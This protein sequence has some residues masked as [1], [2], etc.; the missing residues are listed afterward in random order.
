[1]NYIN[2]IL[3]GHTKKLHKMLSC[4]ADNNYNHIMNWDHQGS[5]SDEH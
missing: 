2:Y 5:V 3:I 4:L 1:M